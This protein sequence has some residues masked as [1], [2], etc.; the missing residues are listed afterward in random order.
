MFALIA[1]SERKEAGSCS[2]AIKTLLHTFPS[3]YPHLNN[4]DKFS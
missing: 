1:N 4:L 3:K 2:N